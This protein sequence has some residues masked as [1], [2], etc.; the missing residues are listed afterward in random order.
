MAG[1]A[2]PAGLNHRDDMAVIAN[3]VATVPK[4]PGRWTAET[5]FELENFKKFN[6]FFCPSMVAL[7]GRALSI[8]HTARDFP[9]EARLARRYL[10]TLARGEPTSLIQILRIDAVLKWIAN[11]SDANVRAVTQVAQTGTPHNFLLAT[12]AIVPSYHWVNGQLLKKL[13]QVLD[14]TRAELGQIVLGSHSG[15]PLIESLEEGSRDKSGYEYRVTKALAERTYISLQVLFESGNRPLD[16]LPAQ[17]QLFVPSHSAGPGSGR[18]T[19]ALPINRGNQ[20]DAF[21]DIDRNAV[22]LRARTFMEAQRSPGSRAQL[23]RT[24]GST[25]LTSGRLGVHQGNQATHLPQL[26]TSF[27]GRMATEEMR[28]GAQLLDAAQFREFLELLYEALRKNKIALQLLEIL[29]K[30]E[31]YKID[32]PD[33]LRLAYLLGTTPIQIAKLRRVIKAA[34][35]NII[36]TMASSPRRADQDD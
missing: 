15:S 10:S 5:R 36:R 19:L 21:S 7:H 32:F 20:M 25:E 24:T 14:L 4:D 29:L 11:H 17:S 34:A 18:H 22:T 27:S 35:T 3:L 13:R 31:V 30:P 33:N 6:V 9:G 8:E 1:R 12:D 28:S 16:Q 2:S 26:V 23:R